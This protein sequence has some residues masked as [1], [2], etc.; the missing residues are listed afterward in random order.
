M[1]SS[2]AYSDLPALQV[3]ETSAQFLLDPVMAYELFD[4]VLWSL[5]SWLCIESVPMTTGVDA[6]EVWSVTVKRYA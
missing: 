2:G 1:V 6:R 4:Q 3:N 5:V